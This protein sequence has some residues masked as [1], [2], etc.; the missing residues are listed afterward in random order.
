MGSGSGDHV[1][2]SGLRAGEAVSLALDEH[3]L[4]CR[5]LIV[6]GRASLALDSSPA[7]RC[8][9]GPAQPSRT[10]QMASTARLYAKR[11]RTLAYFPAMPAP[12]SWIAQ[13]LPA[14]M[15]ETKHR[16]VGVSCG[17]IV[18][19]ITLVCAIN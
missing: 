4:G 14:D 16:A 7:S 11:R 19:R 15:R 3:R 1:V 13:G 10:S 17:Q 9:P 18:W 6:I 2:A 12:P 5:T 8:G